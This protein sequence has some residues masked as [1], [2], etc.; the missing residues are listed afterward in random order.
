MDSIQKPDSISVQRHVIES[1][2]SPKESAPVLP[3]PLS[4]AMTS[5]TWSRQ[6]GR[7]HLPLSADA[8]WEQH[9]PWQVRQWYKLVWSTHSL[10][11]FVGITCSVEGPATQTRNNQ[12]RWLWGLVTRLAG[13]DAPAT[14]RAELTNFH[15]LGLRWTTDR[16]V[17]RSTG[18]PVVRV[19]VLFFLNLWM[20]S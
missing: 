11:C 16:Y 17:F 9:P 13:T 6:R 12:S 3:V 1:E 7:E 15:T 5:L 2:W 4:P 10:K 19:K 20:S 14:G 8:A 18:G